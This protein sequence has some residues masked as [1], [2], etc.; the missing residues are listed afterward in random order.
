MDGILSLQRNRGSPNL[1]KNDIFD[2]SLYSNSNL[3]ITIGLISS[4]EI[5]IDRFL[6]IEGS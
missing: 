2:I 4:I 6:S 3:S 5:L 1:P